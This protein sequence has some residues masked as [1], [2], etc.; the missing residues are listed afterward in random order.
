MQALKLIFIV[1][2]VLLLA[3]CSTTGNKTPSLNQTLA[4]ITSPT[5]RTLTSVARSGDPKTALKKTLES[6]KSVYET[7]PFALEIY[8]VHAEL[9][10]SRGGGLRRRSG[11]GRDAGR[12][13]P[14]RQPE[15]RHRHHA[16]HAQ[17]SAR[18]GPVLRQ[19][20]HAH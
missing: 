2:S 5:A 19:R 20:H 18:G 10:E 1:L 17:R 16:A 11:D 6:R 8:K 14:A 12:Q 7:N 13:G 4:V 9:H 15:E 3:G